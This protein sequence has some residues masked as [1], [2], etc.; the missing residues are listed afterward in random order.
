MP[1][2]LLLF[3]L[4]TCATCDILTKISSS[5][6]SQ[7]DNVLFASSNVWYKTTSNTLINLSNATT[8]IPPALLP[9]TIKILETTNNRIALFGEFA[10]TTAPV[11]WTDGIKTI[12]T[13][14]ISKYIGYTILAAHHL[15]VDNK[16]YIMITLWDKFATLS[17]ASVCIGLQSKTMYELPF[18][19]TLQSHTFAST[20]SKKYYISMNNIN[21]TIVEFDPITNDCITLDE[22]RKTDGSMFSLNNSIIYQNGPNVTQYNVL[23][24]QRTT[25][26]IEEMIFSILETPSLENPNMFVISTTAN[27][28]FCKG[29]ITACTS[30]SFYTEALTNL[31]LDN[32]IAYIA[33]ESNKLLYYASET[34][35]AL[36]LYGNLKMDKIYDE[37]K[38]VY[39][40]LSYHEHS[41]CIIF[42]GAEKKGVE[43][44]SINLFKFNMKTEMVGMVTSLCYDQDCTFTKPPYYFNSDGTITIIKTENNLFQLYELEIEEPQVPTQPPIDN[45]GNIA[46]IVLG[47]LVGLVVLAFIVFMTVVAINRYKNAIP[48]TPQRYELVDEL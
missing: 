28:L 7:P 35:E 27:T 33:K 29:V 25:T 43:T 34:R 40:F 32:G 2:I 48:N 3:A 15:S 18:P 11:Y 30:A 46:A 39:E 8:N 44:V 21:T 38:V 47:V 14:D 45:P 31:P 41:D 17:Y 6:I 26:I 24:R 13:V 23:T 16:D 42:V 4:L 9:Y 19:S 1:Q 22:F 10:N 36:I 5:P 37:S 20:A 12:E